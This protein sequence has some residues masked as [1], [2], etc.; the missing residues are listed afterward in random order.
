VGAPAHHRRTA[1]TRALRS[2]A[3]ERAEV[4]A[5]PG[6]QRGDGAGDQEGEEEV[7]RAGGEPQQV[8]AGRADE[9][10]RRVE[11]EARRVAL[12]EL[13]DLFPVAWEGERQST[14]PSI[15]AQ[16][17]R[18]SAAWA[19]ISRP[20]TSRRGSPPCSTSPLSRSHEQ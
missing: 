10:A 6:L 3:R 14:R 11:R 12:V 4:R 13:D 18:P 9:Q 1:G 2:S 20:S 7:D 17:W 19:V 5:E 8:G 16:R 15:S